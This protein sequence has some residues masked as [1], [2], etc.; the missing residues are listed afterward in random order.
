MPS[1]KLPNNHFFLQVSN[2]LH[3][4]SRPLTA[5][6]GISQIVYG[7]YYPN[8]DCILLSNIGD[9][10]NHHLAHGYIAPAPIPAHLLIKEKA[11]HLIPNEGSFQQAK[12]DLLKKFNS[13]QSIDFI[14]KN[15]NYYEVFCYA[16]QSNCKDAVNV[17]LNNFDSLNKFV[18]Y[19]KKQSTLSRSLA[20]KHKITCPLSMLGINFENKNSQEYLDLPESNITSLLTARENQVLYHLTLGRTAKKIADIMHLSPRTIEQHIAKIKIKSNC[21]SKAELIEKVIMNFS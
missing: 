15:K 16:F 3:A 21:N 17:I 13:G 7:K 10:I 6:Y 19:F 4:L 20:Q 9:W 5:R 1:V 11:Y 18:D 14:F 2:D 12:Y 8:G